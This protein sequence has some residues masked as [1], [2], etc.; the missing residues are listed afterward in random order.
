MVCLSLFV[1]VGFVGLVTGDF[2]SQPLTLSPPTIAIAD[3]VPSAAKVELDVKAIMKSMVDTFSPPTQTQSQ[4]QQPPPAV[5]AVAGVS[6]SIPIP[7]PVA[8][9][10]TQ[11][12]QLG[13]PPIP[14]PASVS[15]TAKANDVSLCV[16][17][18]PRDIQHLERLLRGVQRQTR[19]PREVIIAI[20]ETSEQSGREL[21]QRLSN[22]Y[23]V[24][25]TTT[26]A[27]QFAGENRN[28][29]VALA[30]SPIVSFIDADDEIHPQRLEVISDMIVETR[31]K[32]IVHSFVWNGHEVDR[33]RFDWHRANIIDGREYYERTIRFDNAPPGSEIRVIPRGLGITDYTVHQGHPSCQRSVALTVRQT[34]VPRGNDC[35]FLR[36]V[37]HQYG[38]EP[39]SLM[40]VNLPLVYYHPS[41]HPDNDIFKGFVSL[42]Q[43]G[44]PA[45]SIQH[46]IEKE[47]S[48]CQC[49]KMFDPVWKEDALTSLAVVPSPVTPIIPITPFK[50]EVKKEK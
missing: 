14:A 46:Q 40:F 18:I 11:A 47:E 33:K 3:M 37:L 26:T 38:P 1:L 16:P 12:P 15:L 43:V 45:N 48:E 42:C 28:R 6:V 36:G 13:S 9:P 31:A 32:C 49:H 44:A 8:A 29:A 30:T 10:P 4:V 5:P 2:P 39:T 20:S 41:D 27:R 34:A 22:I 25:V 7:I 23:P 19:P 21:Q 50:I 17:C 35:M 24:I